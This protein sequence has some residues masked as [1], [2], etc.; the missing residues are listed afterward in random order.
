MP[1]W[2][3]IAAVYLGIACVVG[4]AALVLLADR[5]AARGREHPDDDD[6]G[7]AAAIGLFWPGTVAV[8]VLVAV[9]RSV[10]AGLTRV[11]RW[12]F[13]RRARLVEQAK[14]TEAHTVRWRVGRGSKP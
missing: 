9:V 1:A 2:A 7:F 3:I 13:D 6:L 5:Q 8:L 4:L 11:Q 12:A 10:E 14:H